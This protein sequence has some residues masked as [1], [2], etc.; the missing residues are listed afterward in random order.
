MSLSVHWLG[1]WPDHVLVGRGSAGMSASICACFAVIVMQ[2]PCRRP[3][4]S[5][6]FSTCGM[7]PAVCRSVAT[8]LPEGF[9]RTA[10]EL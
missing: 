6:I 5:R 7:P 3:F 9:S 4:A 2:S 1:K 10:P 8:Y